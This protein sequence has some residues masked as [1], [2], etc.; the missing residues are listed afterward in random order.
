M[1]C[2]FLNFGFMNVAGLKSY[3]QPT[4]KGFRKGRS[5]IRICSRDE[6]LAYRF[7]YHSE[8]CKE[9]YYDVLSA[10]EKE[11]D[12]DQSVIIMRLKKNSEILDRVFN[13]KPVIKLLQKKYPYYSW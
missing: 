5:D 11:F 6:K 4:S 13:D 1:S 12:I 10:L 3:C 9:N 2:G 7:Y 8:I